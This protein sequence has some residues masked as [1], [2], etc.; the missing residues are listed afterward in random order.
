MLLSF[1]T[2]PGGANKKQN[3]I[4]E[5][6]VTS[7][8]HHPFVKLTKIKYDVIF[9]TIPPAPAALAPALSQKIW[10]ATSCGLLEIHS[11]VKMTGFSKAFQI[12]AWVTE[13]ERPKGAKEEVTQARRAA[14]YK[15]GPAGPL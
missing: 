2:P 3:F 6:K 7:P 1:L 5:K 10:M 13:P 9:A 15:S 11:R 12:S 4:R 14:S 8:P